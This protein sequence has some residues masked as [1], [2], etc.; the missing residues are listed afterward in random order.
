VNEIPAHLF[1]CVEVNLAV[2]ADR[3]HGRGTHLRLGRRLGF[4]P[5]AGPEG[6]PTVEP[7]VDTQVAEACAA[8]GL[9]VSPQETDGVRYVLADAYLLPWCPYF[10]QK[11]ITHSFLVESDGDGVVVTDAYHNDTPWGRARPLQHRCQAAELPGEAKSVWLSP[12]ILPAAPEP[13]VD[14]DPDEVRRYVEAYAAHPHRVAALDRLTLETWLLARRRRLHAACRADERISEQWDS[15]VE[16]AYLAY[17]RVAR[18]RAEPPD[19]LPRLREVL[20]ADAVDPSL[21]PAVRTAVATVLG[22]DEVVVDQGELTGI[23]TFSSLRMVEIVEL[24]EDKFA[25]EFDAAL[26]VPERLHR[27]D[28]LCGLVSRALARR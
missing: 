18:G 15:V 6:L 26:L 17:R 24:L 2:L 20:L 12:G 10:G 4:R 9:L 21:R 22:V 5:I 16:H 13:V 19:L 11:H 25:V 28:D 1:D 7:D 23:A 8:L 14:V 3:W 27:L